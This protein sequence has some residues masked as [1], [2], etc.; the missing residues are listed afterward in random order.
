MKGTPSMTIETPSEL[1][2]AAADILERDGWTQGNY[3]ELS[4][5]SDWNPG[6]MDKPC[7]H[8]AVGAMIVALA[9]DRSKTCSE[10]TVRDFLGHSV[11]EIINWND[12]C[13]SKE[14]V[15]KTLR[16]GELDV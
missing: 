14:E 4:N 13:V 8:C 16:R 15:V 2:K 6:L 11:A 5:W 7:A 3:H 9:E 12:E 1:Y 10:A